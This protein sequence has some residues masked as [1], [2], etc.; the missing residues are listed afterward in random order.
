MVK[1][2]S[3]VSRFSSLE[4]IAIGEVDHFSTFGANKM[5][6]VS[7]RTPDIRMGIFT[8]MYHANQSEVRKYI[9]CPVY[10]DFSHLRIRLPNFLIQG[11]RGK[12]F[13]TFQNYFYDGNSLGSYLVARLS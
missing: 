9:Q 8:G 11:R 13:G 5:V 6:M 4:R 2:V 3:D 12:Q 10:R 7:G 1:P